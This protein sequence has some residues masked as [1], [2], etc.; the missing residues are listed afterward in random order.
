MSTG[1]QTPLGVNVTAS[2]LQNIGF[3][4]NPTAQSYMGTSK[5]NSEYTFGKV[6][7]DTYLKPLV[8][9]INDAYTRSVAV[10]ST[11]GVVTGSVEGDVFTVTAISSGKITIGSTISGTGVLSNTKVISQLSGTIGG[12][13][14]YIL[15]TFKNVSSTTIT[16][17]GLTAEWHAVTY[18]SWST[19]L[20][21]Y[22]IWSG[23]DTEITTRSYSTSI[24][25]P[26]TE[27]YTF[28][29]QADD[30]IIVLLD[31][32]KP[33]YVGLT[34]L[35]NGEEKTVD[36]RI[37]NGIH[38]ITMIIT[39]YRGPGAGAVRVTDSDGNEVWK[40]TDGIPVTAVDGPTVSNAN[41]D[42][43]ISI[44]KDVMPIFGDAAPNTY[45]N[46]D[47]SNKWNGQATTGYYLTDDP[48]PSQGQ[49]QTATWIPYNI[50]NTNNSITQWGFL[51]NYALQAWNEFNWNGDPLGS[52]MPEYKDFTASFLTA[53]TFVKFV[54]T[55]IK[56]F[57]NAPDFL[58]GTYSNMNDLISSDITGVSLAT[59]VFGEDCIALGR[60]ID[61][62]KI[63]T[64]GL[65]SVLL[66]TIKKNKIL[67]QSLS[68][69]LLASGLTVNEVNDISSGAIYPVGKDKEQKI[70]GAFL[71]IMGTDLEEILFALNCKT[72]GLSTLADLLNIKKIFPNSYK[73]LTVPIYNASPGPT[74][75]KTYYPI[76]TNE[77][78]S[79]RITS[80]EVVA[81]VGEI[82]PPGEPPIV[83][84]EVVVI[85]PPPLPVVEPVI[86]PTVPE[87]PLSPII[88]AVTPT[89]APATAPIG[90][91]GC[92]A[93]WMKIT[94]G[95]KTVINA[96]DIKVG[97]EVYTKHETTGVW[98]N[99]KVTNVTS[100]EDYRW[101]VIC[102]DDSKFIGTFNHR[103]LTDKGWVELNKLEPNDNIIT[104]DDNKVR[105][106]SVNNYD[107]GEV[108]KITVEDAHTYVC[109]N[110][111][112]HNVK[113]IE[114]FTK[115]NLK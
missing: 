113:Y 104:F 105:V 51:R 87:A 23:P 14:V 78:V 89:P 46:Y 112:S 71:V 98:G 3:Y 40:S 29:I 33:V 21:T 53:D 73:T 85:V 77:T 70:Y 26:R 61:L 88:P 84:P 74:N 11:I 108:I 103:F 45:L 92:P 76:Y 83:E 94:L 55:G 82:I 106:V 34:G 91:G 107:M 19:F 67:T 2:Q 80:P 15:D 10:G 69:A 79:S 81:Q 59:R 32:E 8:Y 1:K 43:L 102:D 100:M 90:R 64:F 5:V 58:K 95:D 96:G 93:P 65:P 7:N 13:G 111:V 110:L 9:A 115:F 27:T 6:V 22:G 99:Y 114:E 37:K 42:E 86:P 66:Q 47:P 35:S 54:N 18:P 36:T 75:S 31:Y 39:N 28:T 16:V 41:Y 4:I 38:T 72:K 48:G 20:N 44:G 50:T 52:G 49:T 60:A 97:M 30:Y 56:S 57:Q 101:V 17:K 109:E 25:I 62:S 68:F 63:Q 24:S 12:I